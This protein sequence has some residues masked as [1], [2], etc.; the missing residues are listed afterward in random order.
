MAGH[1]PAAVTR[2]QSRRRAGVG[3]GRGAAAPGA[4]W[5]LAAG[6]GSRAWAWVVV[7]WAGTDGLATALPAGVGGGGGDAACRQPVAGAVSTL[8]LKP[9]GLEQGRSSLGGR[10]GGAAVASAVGDGS[11]GRVGK[12]QGEAGRAEGI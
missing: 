7:A 3:R 9:G 11:V 10:R 4:A 1:Q 5:R 12:N 8:D 6:R 2:S